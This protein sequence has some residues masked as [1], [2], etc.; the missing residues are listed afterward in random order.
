MGRQWL[1]IPLGLLMI[2][3]SAYSS[4]EKRTDLSLTIAV[5]IHDGQRAI[6]VGCQ[7]SGFN[8]IVENLS[9]HRVNLWREWCS[10]GYFNLM[11]KFTGEKVLRG[12]Q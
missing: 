3:L 6:Q 12:L 7:A 9:E 4:E 2:L 5:P 11:F 1:V 8:E 10:W